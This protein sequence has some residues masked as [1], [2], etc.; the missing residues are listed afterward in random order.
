MARYKSPE[1]L[2]RY[3]CADCLHVWGEEIDRYLTRIKELEDGLRAVRTLN[4]D[5]FGTAFQ[6]E[7]AVR[8][9]ANGAL[10][11]RKV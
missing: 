10:Q 11:G 6:Y 9:H 2:R 5:D 1:Q 4:H 8:F 3:S 7:Q